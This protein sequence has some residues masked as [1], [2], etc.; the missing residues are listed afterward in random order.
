MQL[1]LVGK[2]VLVLGMG[3]SGRSAAE[4]L[5]AHGAIVY[6]VDRDEK[7]LNTH[8]D[9]LALVKNGLKGAI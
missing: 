9:I 6:G 8:S 2:R 3:M 5:M 7:L 1:K 4:F